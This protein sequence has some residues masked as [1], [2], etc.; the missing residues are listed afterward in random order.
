ME[1]ERLIEGVIEFGL[2]LGQRI[3]LVFQM[4]ALLHQLLGR[5]RVIPQG[6]VLG[7]FV[8]FL[9]T[10]ICDVPVKDASSAGPAIAAPAQRHG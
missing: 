10:G 1:N 8:Q 5:L 3:D 6:G 9:E 7:F 2:D 4:G